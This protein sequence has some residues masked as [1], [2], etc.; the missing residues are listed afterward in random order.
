MS[1]AIQRPRRARVNC[2]LF[3]DHEIETI[4]NCKVQPRVLMARSLARSKDGGPDSTAAFGQT[5]RSRRQPRHRRLLDLTEKDR[6]CLNRTLAPAAAC[7]RADFSCAVFLPLVTSVSGH[8]NIAVRQCRCL[9]VYGCQCIFFSF[10]FAGRGT[11]ADVFDREGQ[12][13]SCQIG[14]EQGCCHVPDV[15]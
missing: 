1:P 5:C 14:S 6:E 7:R 10:L 3:F 13:L 8:I 2:L 9:I 11:S 15:E 12:P 4:L